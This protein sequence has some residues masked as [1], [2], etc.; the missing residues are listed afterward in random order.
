MMEPKKYMEFT[1]STESPFEGHDPRAAPRYCPVCGRIA[2]VLYEADSHAFRTVCARC[3]CEC[4]ISASVC[5][6][7]RMVE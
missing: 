3:G 5:R 4:R 7:E 6:Y 1:L 2:S